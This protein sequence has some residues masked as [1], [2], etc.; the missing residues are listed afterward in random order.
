MIG[1]PM[2]VLRAFPVRR[3]KMQKQAFRDAVLSY[4]SELGYQ[5]RV[6]KGSR[7]SHNVLIGNPE[8]A[9]LLV[10]AHYDTCVGLPFPNIVTPTNLLAYL[11]Y[12][13]SIVMV[14]LAIA[15]GVGGLIGAM[16]KDSAIATMSGLL[17]YYVLLFMMLYGP[18]NKH[19]ANDNTS[20]VVTVLEIAKLLPAQFRDKVCFVLFDLEESG[21]VGSASYRKQHKQASET[22]IIL[23]LDCVGDGDEMIL[24]PGKKARK[25]DALMDLLRTATGAWGSK[26]LHLHEKGFSMYPSDQKHFPLGVAIGAFHRKKWVGPYYSRIHTRRD[27]ILDEENVRILRDRIIG[28]IRA[29]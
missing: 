9:K 25:N 7:G 2:D 6:E 17:I 16:V 4:T 13:I 28:L 12:Q 15:F 5:P 21:L 1:N 19:N 3:S 20:G 29:V 8:T 18:A 11:V 10:T 14:Y 27:T 22:Q 26:S 23:N 24:L